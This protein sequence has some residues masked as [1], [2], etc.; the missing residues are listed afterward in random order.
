MTSVGY[1]GRWLP[2]A[3]DPRMSD[4][5]ARGERAV[6]VE[7]LEHYRATLELKC[8]GLDAEQLARRA[9]PPSTLSL[10][11]LVRH[12][13]QMEHH[14]FRRVLQQQPQ[15]TQLF[16]V[17]GDWEAQ[18]DGAV[19]DPAVVAEALSTWRETCARADA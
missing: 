2:Q 16:V 5:P 1:D 11:G 17:G 3:E 7:Y 12:L 14:W 4:T 18:F 9:V 6:L 8:E 13:A 15:E 19:A 10:L